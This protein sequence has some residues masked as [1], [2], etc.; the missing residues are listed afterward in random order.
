[1]KTQSLKNNWQYLV[2]AVLALGM[3]VSVTWAYN[4]GRRADNRTASSTQM[5]RQED[6]A[7]HL[8]EHG[9]TPLDSSQASNSQSTADELAYLIEEEKLAHDVYQAMYD[10][11]GSRVFGNI[12]ESETKHGDM[13]L[14]VM[15]S[16]DLA[17]PRSEEFGK[18]VNQDLQKLYDKLVAQGNQSAQDAFKVGVTIEET[19]IAD[20]NNT[21]SKLDPKDTD[22]KALV[23][24]LI[25]ASENHLRAF[26]RQLSR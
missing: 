25:H 3:V 11:W 13:V 17:D 10:K 16:R 2:I 6:A 14:A 4:E 18:F 1:M 26:N 19:D 21:L 24:N 12:K 8:E 20:L 5:N 23:E 22:I 15:N 9:I 7:Q